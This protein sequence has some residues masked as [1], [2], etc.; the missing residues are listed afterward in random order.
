MFI[1]GVTAAAEYVEKSTLVL[2]VP[3]SGRGVTLVLAQGGA[4]DRR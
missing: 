2:G 1:F 4:V 3:T